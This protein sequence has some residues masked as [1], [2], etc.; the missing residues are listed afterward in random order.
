MNILSGLFAS[1][2]EFIASISTG[3]CLFTSFDEET[4]PEELL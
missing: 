1:L 2:G 4:M 3:A